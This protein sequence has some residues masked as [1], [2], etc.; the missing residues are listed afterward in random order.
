M[1]FQK[2][3][4]GNPGGR[5]KVT[6]ADGRTLTDV[7][8]EHT[9]DAVQALRRVLTDKEAP[10]VAKV[11]AAVALLDR[12]WGRPRQD[13]GVD[14]MVGTEVASLLEEARKRARDAR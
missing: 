5:A 6:L 11:S 8:R 10:H 13:M 1:P 4:S 14:L 12:G 7:A 2:G 9:V 3:Q